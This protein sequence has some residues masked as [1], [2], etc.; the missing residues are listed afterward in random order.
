MLPEGSRPRR[1]EN[2]KGGAVVQN[3]CGEKLKIGPRSLHRL[4]DLLDIDEGVKKEKVTVGSHRISGEFC[5]SDIRRGI[6]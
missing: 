3:S 6:D 1:L 4:G 5:S 2:W